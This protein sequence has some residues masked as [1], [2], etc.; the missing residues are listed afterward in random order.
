MGRVG[1]ERVEADEAL[2]CRSSRASRLPSKLEGWE[3][4]VGKAG[5][6]SFLVGGCCEALCCELD[7]RGLAKSTVRAR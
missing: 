2:R 5:T 3:A 6:M 7:V 4:C 1:R